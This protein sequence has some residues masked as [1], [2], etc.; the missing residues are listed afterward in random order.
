[1]NKSLKDALSFLVCKGSL[2]LYEKKKQAKNFMCIVSMTIALNFY[3][4]C[5]LEQCLA[6][7]NPI[8]LLVIN[9][10]QVLLLF[11]GFFLYCRCYW[12]LG[13]TLPTL[14]CNKLNYTHCC[15]PRSL[16]YGSLFFFSAS[17]FLL[18]YSNK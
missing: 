9:P 15:L 16:F 18:Y 13:S 1:M 11:W 2:W 7:S 6:S 17:T 4:T 8:Q 14:S 5:Y 3:Y 10:P 12:H